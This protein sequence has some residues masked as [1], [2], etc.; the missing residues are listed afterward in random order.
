MNYFKQITLKNFR[1]YFNIVCVNDT[2]RQKQ[3]YV[4][5]IKY[6][7]KEVGIE[8]KNNTT[9]I[10]EVEDLHEDGDYGFTFYT[11]DG[12]VIWELNNVYEPSPELG[13]IGYKLHDEYLY[14]KQLT[15]NV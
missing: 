4:E 9:I 13:E 3:C 15:L 11:T 10:M 5:E 2:P 12:Q 1:D 7:L 14:S 8:N 6:I